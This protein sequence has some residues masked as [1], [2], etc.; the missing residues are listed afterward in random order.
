MAKMFYTL[1]EAAQRLGISEED[2]R[3]LIDSNQ[4]EEFRDGDE[5][6]LKVE[7]VDLLA[8]ADADDSV[9]PLADSAELEPIGLSSSGSGSVFGM[10]D[11]SDQTGI[12]IFDPE[13]E[14]EVDPSAATQVASTG[15][16]MDFSSV[17][18][19]GSGLANIA[20]EADDTSIGADILE[21][22]YGGDPAAS[23]APASDSGIGGS[24]ALDT[25][26]DLFETPAGE[27]DLTPVAPAG[28]AVA[29]A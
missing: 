19:S 29:M 15:P 26:G 2:V 14:D 10:D 4:L 17:T 8:G 3:G 9:I 6:K 18:A 11:G 27:S 5:T 16:S 20:L 23:G 25:G 7:Q 21:D 24:A 12:S 13:A 28:G 1:S 22:V